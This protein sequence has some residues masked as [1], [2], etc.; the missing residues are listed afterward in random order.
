MVLLLSRVLDVPLRER[1]SLLLAAGF[2]PEYTESRLDAPAL[3][4]VRRALDA[5]ALQQEPFP[6]VVMSRHWDIL[7]TN[8]AAETLFGFLLEGQPLSGANNVL[9][10][11]F[12]PDGLR[13]FVSNW[14]A[15]AESLVGRAHREAV[16]GVKDE[17]TGKLLTEIMSYPGVPSS[18]TQPT[19]NSAPLLPMLPVSFKKADRP[20][21]FFS[22]VTTLGTPQDITV[23]EIR[24]ECFFP[25]DEATAAR[26]RAELAG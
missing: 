2:A 6:A 21:N 26:A 22:T 20:F 16:G 10:L 18:W 11:F 3:E 5:I 17:A 19:L 25:A 12:H 14:E 7:K 9:R 8:R 1:N 13:P 4:T 15:V 23:Q 24:I